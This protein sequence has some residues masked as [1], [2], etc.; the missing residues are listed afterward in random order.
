M[1]VRRRAPVKVV[2]FQWPCGMGERHRA[3][4]LARPRM[5]DIFVVAPVSSIKTSLSGLRSG[6]FLNQARRRASTSSRS[7]SLAC[8][9]F[10]DGHRV[11]VEK[12]PDRA[13]RKQRS[14][15][16]TQ[17]PCQFDKGDIHLLLDRLKDHVTIGFNPPGA[18]IAALGFGRSRPALVPFPKPANRAGSSNPKSVS[19]RPPGQAAFNRCDD[20][21]TKIFRNGSGHV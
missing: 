14:V 13:G 18:R 20:P 8:A 9:V 2:V 7:C 21:R 17:Q 16:C 15:I 12:T 19:R 10:F 5:R 1:P 4:R 6:W 3:P 11:T